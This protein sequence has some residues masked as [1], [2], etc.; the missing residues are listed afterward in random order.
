MPQVTVTVGA[1]HFGPYHPM[2]GVTVVTDRGVL[3]LEKCWPT[4]VRI[5]LGLGAKQLGA[6]GT[7]TVNPGPVF[8]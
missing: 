8:I 4:A 6:T 5:K 3:R 2:G 7:T 1:A